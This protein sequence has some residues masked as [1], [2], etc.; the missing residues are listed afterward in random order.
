VSSD[1]LD[2]VRAAYEHPDG[3]WAMGDRVAADAQF[4]YR[5]VYPDRPIFR[6]ID[7]VRSFRDQGPWAE[8]RFEPERFIEVDD[9]RVLVIVKVRFVGK[10]SGASVEQSAAH[11][12]RVRGGILVGFKAYLDPKR[13]LADCGLAD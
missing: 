4:D 9:E 2:W 3:L 5:D 13:A 7:A 11:V 1:N 10:E 8:I 12:L 6:G